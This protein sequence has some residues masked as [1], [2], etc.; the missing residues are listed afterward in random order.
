MTNH[1]T[2][3]VVAMGAKERLMYKPLIKLLNLALDK[4][5]QLQPR[6][7]GLESDDDGIEHSQEGLNVCGDSSRTMAAPPEVSD[8]V[9]GE[10]SGL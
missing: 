6:P 10:T 9:N 1:D 3:R 5:Q 8:L 2:S 7:Q 4:L